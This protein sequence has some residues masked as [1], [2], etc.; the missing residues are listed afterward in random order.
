MCPSTISRPMS[1]ISSYGC[2]A[3][4]S[5]RVPLQ[6]ENQDQKIRPVEVS[7]AAILTNLLIEMRSPSCLLDVLYPIPL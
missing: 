7:L 3:G 6:A 1:F 4:V 5:E 2:T